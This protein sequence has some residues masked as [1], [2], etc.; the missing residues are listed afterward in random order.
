MDFWIGDQVWIKSK[1]ESGVFEG[2]TGDRSAKIRVNDQI[3]II[4]I[5]ELSPKAAPEKQPEELGVEQADLVS[6]KFN[7]SIDLHAD[8]LFRYKP[9]SNRV[10]SKQLDECRKFIQ[11]AIEFKVNRIIIIHGKGEG[12]LAQ[13]VE[14]LLQTFPEVQFVFSIHDHGAKEVHL[15]TH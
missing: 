6:H 7:N 1:G 15:Y 9:D 11:K 8:K 12:I 4:P 3:F 14:E 13:S 5:R 2:E 10:L